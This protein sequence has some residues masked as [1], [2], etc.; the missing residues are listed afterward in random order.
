MPA[1]IAHVLIEVVFSFFFSSLLCKFLECLIGVYITV[2]M[3]YSSG[4]LHRRCKHYVCT[5]GS[6]WCVVCCRARISSEGEEKN[7]K[8]THRTSFICSIY[9]RHFKYADGGH[10][11][12]YGVTRQQSHQ[13]DQ[14]HGDTLSHH[15]ESTGELEISTVA[16]NWVTWFTVLRLISLVFQHHNSSPHLIVP[17][18]LCIFF[19]SRMVAEPLDAAALLCSVY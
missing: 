10:T 7:C 12:S 8:P 19:Y 9:P 16:F 17:V 3:H 13:L 18:E 2:N 14:R 6:L 1:V 15:D 4:I 11:E 5:V